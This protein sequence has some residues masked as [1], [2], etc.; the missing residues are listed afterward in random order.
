MLTAPA[1]CGTSGSPPTARKALNRPIG[2]SRLFNI[3]ADKWAAV[4]GSD[5]Y[6]AKVEEGFQWARD[7]LPYIN[8]VEY[9]KYPLIVNKNLRNVPH[10]RLRHWRE[11]QHRPDVLRNP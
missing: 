3:D 2:S 7:N 10:R 5:E 8:F 9:V 1:G 6:N 11:L 4:A